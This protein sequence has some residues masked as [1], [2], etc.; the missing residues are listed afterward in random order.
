M[1]KHYIYKYV[2]G[3]CIIYIGQTTDL[4]SRNSAHHREDAFRQ[5]SDADLF[6]FICSNSTECD[7]WEKVLI[8]K[9]SPILNR[10]SKESVFDQRLI[11]HDEPKWH[12]YAELLVEAETTAELFLKK[13]RRE[14]KREKERQKDRC[15]ALKRIFC[16]KGMLHYA[17][18][19][20]TSKDIVFYNSG[21][22]EWLE[23]WPLMIKQK[24][25][26]GIID[27]VNVYN[28]GEVLIEINPEIVLGDE[29]AYQT[30]LRIKDAFY[31]QYDNLF[32]KDELMCIDLLTS[33]PY[34]FLEDDFD[35]AYKW[36][37]NHMDTIVT[38]FK[39]FNIATLYSDRN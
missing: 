1:K 6:F 24:D 19:S 20:T 21:G 23:N 8:N 34:L 18:Y 25:Y 16:F 22:H 13:L 4:L 11:P 7:V 27:C 30:L 5:Y 14:E 36:L 26:K 39:E 31:K 37:N 10:Q 3:N 33:S 12:C 38:S 28:D 15:D 32:S 29:T 35:K 2:K 9:Y 17:F